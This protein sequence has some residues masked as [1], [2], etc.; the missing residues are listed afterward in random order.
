MA[1]AANLE[2]ASLAY[3]L[4]RDA[5]LE[6]LDLGVNPSLTVLRQDFLKNLLAAIEL[7]HA[8]V[9]QAH[10]RMAGQRVQQSMYRAMLADT[11][12]ITEVRREEQQAVDDRAEAARLSDMEAP[13]VPEE[14]RQQFQGVDYENERL[15]AIEETINTALTG[16][17]EDEP[18]VSGD[19]SG[20]SDI[21]SEGTLVDGNA[22]TAEVNLEQYM[23]VLELDERAPNVDCVV[24]TGTFRGSQAVRFQCDHAW[25]RQCLTIQFEEATVNEGAWP[26]KCCGQDMPVEDVFRI[27]S[28]GVR[29]R[30]ATKSV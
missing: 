20:V 3:Q 10:C 1:A 4:E 18:T 13:Q 22:G 29:L 14:V 7:Q 27:L 17:I 11:N 6:E 16:L 25:C 21:C 8:E 30:F 23:N 24:C 9:E 5:I 2:N 28:A 12:V 15:A 19:D 26:P